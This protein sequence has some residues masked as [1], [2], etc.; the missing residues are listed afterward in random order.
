MSKINVYFSKLEFVSKNKE[1]PLSKD[2]LILIKKAACDFI[3]TDQSLEDDKKIECKTSQE[4]KKENKTITTETIYSPSRNEPSKDGLALQGIIIK[5]EEIV[6][7]KLNPKSAE[8]EHLGRSKTELKAHFVYSSVYDSISFFKQ[9][10]FGDSKFLKCFKT[11]IE[12][13]IAFNITNKFPEIKIPEFEA[14]LTPFYGGFYPTN[15]LE[16]TKSLNSKIKTITACFITANP[17]LISAKESLED[18]NITKYKV[19]FE[20]NGDNGINLN[21]QEIQTLNNQIQLFYNQIEENFELNETNSS[22]SMNIETINKE[23]Y[24]TSKVN[25]FTKEINDNILPNDFYDLS[26]EYISKLRNDR[27]D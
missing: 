24:S 22:V 1:A 21:S 18:S 19:I 9:D 15:F 20:S 10:N 16:F 26:M 27:I 25:K 8:I 14:I 11:I 6:T 23:T 17:L 3:N 5:N 2:E 12:K 13:S 7:V 4:I